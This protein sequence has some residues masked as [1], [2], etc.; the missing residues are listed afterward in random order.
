MDNK[1]DMLM[2]PC[3][4]PF[5]SHTS[6]GR[7]TGAIPNVIGMYEKKK[8]TWFENEDNY[9]REI[10]WSRCCKGC[11]SLTNSENID[12]DAPSLG[13]KNYIHSL[14]FKMQVNQFQQMR[15]YMMRWNQRGLTE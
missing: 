6:V 12:P 9:V 11:K 1:C 15:E 14:V 7:R 4:V 2:N 8:L 10:D 13:G 5:T 3:F